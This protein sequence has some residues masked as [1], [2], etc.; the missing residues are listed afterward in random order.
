[1]WLLDR[2]SGRVE[3]T[4]DVGHGVRGAPLVS[5]GN[6]FFLSDGGWF[7]GYRFGRGAR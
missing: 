5:R 3:T 1:V 7:H 4:I 2:R 6:I